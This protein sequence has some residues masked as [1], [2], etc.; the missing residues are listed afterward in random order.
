MPVDF[1]RAVEKAKTHFDSMTDNDLQRLQAEN[2][3]E[4]REQHARFRNGYQQGEC[5]LC[6]KDFKTL[7]KDDPCL[8]WLLRLGKFKPK[9]INLIASKFG[10]VQVA[11]YLRWC[12]NEEK[13]LANINDLEDEAPKGKFL[14]STIRWKGIEWTF[15]CSANDLSGHGGA[16]SNFPHYHFQMRID[17]RQFINFNDYHLPFSDMDLFAFKL[18]EQPGFNFD[19]GV[20]GAGMA[21]AMQ[22]DPELIIENTVVSEDEEQAGFGFSTMIM[23]ANG[24]INGDDLYKMIQESRH[25]GKS[26]ASI[27]RKFYEDDKNIS[28]ETIISPSESVPEIAARTEMKRR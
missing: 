11:A 10:Y 1:D 22:L 2:D 3:E 23:S 14:S 12:A 16:H 9:D 5:Y 26:I 27:S 7:S 8:H 19:F 18:R 24:T 6:G 21:D 13:P 17:G 28:I 15:D 20:H 25:T 4:H